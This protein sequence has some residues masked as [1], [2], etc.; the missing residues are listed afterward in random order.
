MWPFS[1]EWG[2]DSANHE[3]RGQN[4]SIFGSMERLIYIEPSALLQEAKQKGKETH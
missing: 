1:E 4:P 3:F 2:Y